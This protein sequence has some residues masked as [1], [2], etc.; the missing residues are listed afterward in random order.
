MSNW[1]RVLLVIV[2]AILLLPATCSVAFT[3]LTVMSLSGYE[4]GSSDP[5]GVFAARL[6]YVSLGY[7]IALGGA[8]LLHASKR[9]SW[10]APAPRWLSI[11]TGVVLLL[12][13]V[14]AAI[15]IWGLVSG[16]WSGR[17]EEHI[18]L[19]VVAPVFV[20]L[21]VYNLWRAWRPHTIA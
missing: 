18:F 4:V 5:R 2:G 16:A 11:C 8:R 19:V 9:G 6:F 13:G 3:P 15:V 7:A 20:I 1:E 10:S 17:H 12:P 21:G 14:S